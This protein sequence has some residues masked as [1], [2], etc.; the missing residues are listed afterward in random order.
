MRALGQVGPKSAGPKAERAL[1]AKDF[2][3]RL[4]LAHYANVL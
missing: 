3:E 2:S 4:N 1:I